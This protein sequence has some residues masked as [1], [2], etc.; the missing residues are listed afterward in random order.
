[1][2][3][4]IIA[5]VLGAALC[6]S[7][8]AA[9]CTGEGGESGSE[10]AQDAVEEAAAPDLEGE[11]QQTNSDSDDTYMVATISGDA[12]AVWWHMTDDDGTEST[13]IYWIGTFEAPSD[14][15]AYT[16][17]SVGDRTQLDSALLAA[18]AETK[19]FTY[20]GGVLSFELTALGTTT[21]IRME[22]VSDE[23]ETEISLTET[24]DEDEEVQAIE[25]VESGYYEDD[26]YIYYAVG[27]YNP[28]ETYAVEYPTLYIT[29]YAE[30]GSIAFSD[31][32]TMEELLPGETQYFAGWAG[33]SDAEFATVEFSVGTNDDYVASD[34]EAVECYEISNTSVVEDSYDASITGEI[35]TLVDPDDI[36]TAA[37][38]VVLRDE[39]GAIVY[40]DYH[41]VDVAA[42]GSTVAFEFSLNYDLPDYASY[43]LYAY[44][45]F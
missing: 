8:G 28:N 6:A 21:T 29:G 24:S 31:S 38:Y 12:I 22:K 39:S 7:L 45:A 4:Q 18:S 44:P 2:K 10:G 23:V 1:M 5:L 17:E 33:S 20:E 27:W 36:S 25:I 42:E 41:Y 19:E 15:A 37:M 13:S 35:T 11:W 9:G 14:D 40:G 43:E 3:R 34:E 32:A 16:W 26:G 30:D